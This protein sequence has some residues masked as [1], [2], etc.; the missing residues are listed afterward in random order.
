MTY[1]WFVLLLAALFLAAC[2][3]GGA[4]SI[5][6]IEVSRLHA[7]S[8]GKVTGEIAISTSLPGYAPHLHQAKFNFAA[9][10]SRT[11]LSRALNERYGKLAHWGTLL[12]Q[13]C[14]YTL[15]R[16]R[17]GEPVIELMTGEEVSPPQYFLEPIIIK[18]YPTIIFGDP[19]TA[20]STV[21]L[22]F[23]QIMEKAWDDFDLDLT[24]PD[25][26]IRSLYLD[27]ETDADTV[28]WI[29]TKLQRGMK[30]PQLKLRYRRC[31]LPLAQDVD[32]IHR[33]IYDSKAEVII[34]DSLGLA[35]GG[36]F[37]D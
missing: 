32:Q 4:P 15:D 6:T 17:K 24:L 27:Y 1:R 2:G 19:G 7:H 23:A 18:N 12:E 13:L 21:A 28:T 25:R 30:L 10:R 35:C 5:N 16:V 26:E 22:I 34:I 20:K 33:H 31:A 3:G 37:K 11:E 29:L 36:D 14:V 8:D 9:T